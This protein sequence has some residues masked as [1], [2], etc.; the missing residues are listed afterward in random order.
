MEGIVVVRAGLGLLHYSTVVALE[1]LEFRPD[2]RVAFH[3]G[4]ECRFQLVEVALRSVL[5]LAIP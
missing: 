4:F 3:E 2:S 5:L 1:S